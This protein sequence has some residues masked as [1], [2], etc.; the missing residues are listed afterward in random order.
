MDA[1]NKHNGARIFVSHSHGDLKKVC[2]IHNEPERR[3]HN[4]KVA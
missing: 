2:P 3:E 4:D 1:T